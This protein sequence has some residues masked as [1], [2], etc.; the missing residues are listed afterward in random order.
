MSHTSLVYGY[1][2]FHESLA[3]LPEDV[4]VEMATEVQAM[5]AARTLGE[6]RAVEGRHTWL[7]F[8]EESEDDDDTAFDV[9]E[10]A[11]FA[12]GDWPPMATQY[13]L[14]Q[15]LFPEELRED[16]GQVVRTT[17]NGDYLKIP[18]SREKEVVALLGEHGFVC[19]RDDE[20]VL[21]CSYVGENL[22]HV[23][24]RP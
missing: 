12:D 10:S 16:I 11:A 3:F 13:A 22:E 20:L 1:D 6:A 8:D 7:P 5:A 23:L 24:R 21:R 2:P 14:D 4:A 17:L 9:E 18:A 19:R 15:Q